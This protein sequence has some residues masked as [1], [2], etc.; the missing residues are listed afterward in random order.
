[1][2]SSLEGHGTAP[3]PLTWTRWP[4]QGSAWVPL[5]VLSVEILPPDVESR[6]VAQNLGRSGN[7][8]RRFSGNRGDQRDRRDFSKLLATFF[9]K[10]WR[11]KR[12]SRLLETLR[13]VFQKVAAI[14]E[15]VAT[16]RNFSR[17]FSRSRDFSKP[18]ATFFRKS[19]DPVESR[20]I[21]ERVEIRRGGGRRDPSTA[22]A[23]VL[24]PLVAMA[25]GGVASL[26]RRSG[27]REGRAR[28]A[29]LERDRASDPRGRARSRCR[30]RDRR[31]RRC[32]RL[33][34]R[35]P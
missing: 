35:P 7:F 26:V 2:V 25:A 8:A 29:R 11:S 20:E 33:R 15:I 27:V 28:P 21:R 18:F 13:D 9:R 14:E 4:L 12:S 22:G 16:S 3:R 1:M 6:A 5:S 23:P 31:R 32:L 24:F 10:P 30:C 19:R 34:G 17:R